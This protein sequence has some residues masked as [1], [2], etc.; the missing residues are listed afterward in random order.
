MQFELIQRVLERDTDM[1]MSIADLVR[2]QQA[3]ELP[4]RN[5]VRGWLGPAV[6]EPLSIGDILDIANFLGGCI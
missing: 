4:V 2:L 1:E 3:Y 5:I 6:T